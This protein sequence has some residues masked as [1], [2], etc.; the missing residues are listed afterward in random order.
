MIGA[1]RCFDNRIL[2]SLVKLLSRPWLIIHVFLLKPLVWSYPLSSSGS[3]GIATLN[4][5]MNVMEIL[6]C[7][8][9]MF[10]K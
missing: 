7:E 9:K 5:T 10:A 2:Y 8:D 3:P 4:N 1:V 6:D